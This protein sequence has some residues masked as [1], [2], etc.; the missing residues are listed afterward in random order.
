METVREN[1]VSNPQLQFHLVLT[2]DILYDAINTASTFMTV[3]IS[4]PM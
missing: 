2:M 4:E 1:Q 3:L